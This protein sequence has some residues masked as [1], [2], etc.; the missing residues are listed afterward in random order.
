MGTPLTIYNTQ[1]LLYSYL[2]GSR[3]QSPWVYEP[4]NAG[5]SE[6][7]LWEVLR[8]DDDVVTALETR[9]SNLIRP[10]SVRPNPHAGGKNGDKSVAESSRRLAAIVAEAIT[11]ISRF[12]ASRRILSDAYVIGRRYAEIQYEEQRTSLDG[13]AEMDWILPVAVKDVDRR[14]F[15]WVTDWAEGDV[16]RKTGVHLEMFDTNE[17]KWVEMPPDLR[18]R[19]IEYVWEDTEDRLGY[20]RGVWEAMFYLHYFKSGSL[21]KLMEGLDRFANGVL[22]GRLD[23]LRA[24]STDLDNVTLIANMKRELQKMRTEHLIVLGEGDDVEIMDAPG[25]GMSVNMDAI[26]YFAEKV[27]RLL[28]GSVRQAGHSVDGT[29]ARSAAE[30]ESD[31]AEH[32]YQFGRD[33]LDDI[34]TRDLVGGFIY[35]NA[36][37][38]QALGLANARKPQF[39]SEQIKRQNPRDR[40][41]VLNQ[42]K[43]PIGKSY[44]YEAIDAPVPE[45]DEETVEPAAAEAP[46]FGFGPKETPKPGEGEK[47][48]SVGREVSV[49]QMTA[50]IKAELWKA[51]SES[52]ILEPVAAASPTPLAPIFN[53]NAQFQMPERVFMNLPQQP[54][55]IVNVPPVTVL[56]TIM[57]PEQRP[58][59]VEVTVSPTPIEFSPRLE[60]APIVMPAPVVN[61]EVKGG[62]RKRVEF[63]TDEKGNITGADIK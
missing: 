45:P 50:E 25:T 37:N 56:N 17:Y 23:S 11:N 44:Y 47:K 22:K 52:R 34:L 46:G 55:P 36:G 12:D 31:T 42:S 9:R 40:V 14:R 18:R 16:R 43:V 10:W 15:H 8:N 29:G 1:D 7:D 41:E 6:P 62:G 2:L 13:T 38:F 54:A 26:R 59:N 35:F 51:F 57:V 33:D 30:T 20:G 19:Y 4:S 61:V 27:H 5:L 24:A 32:F 49:A 3:Y 53:L 60:L 58:P 39:T 21:K 48:E 63:D 28:N